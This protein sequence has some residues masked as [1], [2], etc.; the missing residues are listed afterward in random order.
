MTNADPPDLEELEKQIELA[1]R[2]LAYAR[3]NRSLVALMAE[4]PALKTL[5]AQD[6]TRMRSMR[7]MLVRSLD[8]EIA[9]LKVQPPDHIKLTDF[10]QEWI[11]RNWLTRLRQMKFDAG[12]IPRSVVEL[13]LRELYQEDY[14]VH[15]VREELFELAKKGFRWTSPGSLG[16]LRTSVLFPLSALTAGIVRV[17]ARLIPIGVLGN[18]ATRLAATTDALR[19]DWQAVRE[20]R[21]R[22]WFAKKASEVRTER[23]HHWIQAMFSAVSSWIAGM[24]A[25]FMFLMLC[26]GLATLGFAIREGVGVP[27]HW[28]H[29][30]AA[31]SLPAIENSPP[32]TGV[33][34]PTAAPKNLDPSPHAAMLTSLTALEIILVAPLPYLLIL[35]LSRYIKALAY[36]ERADEFRKELL[37]FKAF[38]VALFIAIIAAAVV[39][40][41]LRD[42]LDLEYAAAVTLV[43]AVFAAYYYLVER[44]AGHVL[45]GATPAHRAVAEPTEVD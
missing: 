26:V 43:V 8:V 17:L 12:L 24:A 25:L 5:A 3:A 44:S 32:V 37:E 29:P 28:Q 35:G 6:D 14:Q 39:A 13:A 31:M 2:Q 42:K 41:I 20:H 19:K 33:T 34:A 18:S 4:A 9:A 1:K 15:E 40:R 10:A 22:Y 30:L 7:D 21:R 36:Q 45:A 23:M 38:E 16:R 11:D 27:W